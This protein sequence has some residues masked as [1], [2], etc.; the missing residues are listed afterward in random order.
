MLNEKQIADNADI[1][2]NGYAFICE[3]NIIKVLNLNNIQSALVIDKQGSVLET[4]M[5]DI[6]IDIVLDY[7]NRNKKYME[8]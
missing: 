5:D 2:V 6:E 7:F 8:V 1:I 3:E 4:T